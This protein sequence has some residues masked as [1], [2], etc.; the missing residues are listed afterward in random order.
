MENIN[1]VHDA[2]IK[3]ALYFT[4][5]CESHDLKYT[6][7]GGTFLGAIRHNGFIPWDDDMDFGMPRKDYDKFIEIMKNEKSIY[8]FKNFRNSAIKTYFSR[9]ED[10]SIDLIDKSAKEIDIRHP[11][12]DIFPIDNVPTNHGLQF[13]FFKYRLLYCRL[14]IQYS[15]FDEIVN[16]NLPNRPLSERIFI[17][18]GKII[19]PEKYID[20]RKRMEILDKTLTKYKNSHSEYAI[21]FSGAYKFKELFKKE[22]YTD[23]KLYSFE[24]YEFFGPRNSDLYLSQLYGSYMVPPKDEHKNKHGIYIA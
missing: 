12:I 2:E 14:M 5:I 24:E 4:K 16:L 8:F 20:T 6:M 15:Q 11:W 7:L 21:N 18:L 22:I 3:I 10:S 1:I 19:K 9:L 23:L 17:F 13:V